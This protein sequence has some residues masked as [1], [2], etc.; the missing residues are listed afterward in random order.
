[1]EKI[2][3]ELK[4]EIYSKTGTIWYCDYYFY[5]GLSSE[6]GTTKAGGYGY[7]KYSTATSNAINKFRYLYKIKNGTKWNGLEHATLKNNKTIYGLYKD[8]SIS[9][10][11]G[12]SSA[13]N[14]LNAFSNVK[15]KTIN[16]GKQSD[17]IHIEITTT[18][19]Q[20]QKEL[21]KQQKIVDN[22]K[23]KKEDRK[24][25]KKIIEKIKKWY[26]MEV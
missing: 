10:G 12:I 15:I 17:F 5:N 16:Y 11:I 25:A 23:A 13:L 4:M 26:N 14:C 22:K 18:K 6:R 24:E 7:D 3:N 8:K 2:K 19:K 20:I 1:M 9:Y 21:E